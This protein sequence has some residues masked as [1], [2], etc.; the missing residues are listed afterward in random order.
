VDAVNKPQEF[1]AGKKL[2]TEK[3]VVDRNRL[4]DPAVPMRELA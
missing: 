1:M 4:A 2:I 3:K